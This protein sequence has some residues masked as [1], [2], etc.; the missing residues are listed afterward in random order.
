[1]IWMV[2]LSFYE[3]IL[4]SRTSID[5]EL[6]FQREIKSV[7]FPLN[8]H[9]WIFI[10]VKKCLFR[11]LKPMNFFFFLS[12][13]QSNTDVLNINF[14]TSSCSR[15]FWKWWFFYTLCKVN[16]WIYRS[17]TLENWPLVFHTNKVGPLVKS[18]NV[19]S[20][21]KSLKTRA[22]TTFCRN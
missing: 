13:R 8:S 18:C 11:Y 6:W 16:A 19:E 10:F 1:M 7:K 4:Y 15:R 9:Q 3:R 5:E 12:N 21:L 20:K 2:A 22:N 17:I 14:Y